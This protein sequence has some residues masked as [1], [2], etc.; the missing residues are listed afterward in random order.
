M[1]SQGD[2]ASSIRVEN[3]TKR[4]GDVVAIDDLSFEV[5]PGTILG[6]L[7]PNGAGKTTTI[8]VL[9]TLLKPDSGEV[10]VGGFDLASDPQEIRRIISMTGQFAAVDEQLSGRENLILFGRLQGLS[11]SD[12]RSRADELLDAFGLADAATRR[13]STYSGGMRRRL[14]IACSLTVEPSILFLD[15]PT[16][17]LDPRS[18]AEM[19]QIVRDL[20]SRGITIVLTTQYLEE[21][22]QLADHIIVIDVGREIASGTPAQLKDMIGGKT[23]VIALVNPTKSDQ[24]I[25]LLADL[26]EVTLSENKTELSIASESAVTTLTHALATLREAS[27]EVQEAAVR[28]PSLDEVF[29]ALTEDG[30][31]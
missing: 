17:G 10:E 18:R 13:V 7:G 11:K 9:C 2:L 15:E 24:A 27:I 23:C 5:K 31:R 20:Q 28:Q 1:S 30:S 8:K 21:A 25:E 29:M 3:L 22:D 14:D 12:A 4:F 16:T 19:W 6:L 26:G